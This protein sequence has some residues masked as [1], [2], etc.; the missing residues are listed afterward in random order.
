M[1]ELPMRYVS[2]QTEIIC[3]I[4]LSSWF[5]DNKVLFTNDSRLKWKELVVN[6]F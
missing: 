1:Q 5:G 6:G 4:F 3:L 2:R